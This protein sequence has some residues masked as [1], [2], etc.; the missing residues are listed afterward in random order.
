MSN[1]CCHI[2][3]WTCAERE[4]HCHSGHPACI[5]LIR[6]CD[7]IQQCSDGSDE[8]TCGKFDHQVVICSIFT[9]FLKFMFRHLWVWLCSYNP[10]WNHH[11]SFLPRNVSQKRRVYLQNFTNIWHIHLPTNSHFPSSHQSNRGQMPWQQD[12]WFHWS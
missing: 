10:K 4:F 7:G 6:I 9:L 3:N 11:F 12:I 8:I 1:K 2:G 5:S